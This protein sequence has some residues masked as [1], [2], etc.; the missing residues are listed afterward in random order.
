MRNMNGAV[1]VNG[2]EASEDPAAEG[3]ADAAEAELEMDELDGAEDDIRIFGIVVLALEVVGSAFDSVG[4]EVGW[5]ESVGV[6]SVAVTAE[7][8]VTVA[9]VTCVVTIS[10]IDLASVADSTGKLSA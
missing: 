6:G 10:M 5:G 8:E 7:V 9:V 1:R 4:V 3:V 2:F